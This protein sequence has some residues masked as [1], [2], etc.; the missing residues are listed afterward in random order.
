MIPKGARVS[1]AVGEY[2]RLVTEMVGVS[3]VLVRRGGTSRKNL[4]REE[5][6]EEAMKR[7]GRPAPTNPLHV[8]P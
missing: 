2:D 5:S 1:K 7:F 3:N 6:P 4:W 8:K